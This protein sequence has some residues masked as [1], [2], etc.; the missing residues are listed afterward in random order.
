MRV[1]AGYEPDIGFLLRRD[2]ERFAPRIA[3]RPL[4]RRWGLRNWFTEA[5]V[6][7]YGRAS[8]GQ[9]ESR[10][11]EIAPIGL[12]TLREDGF[13]LY[14][15]WETERLFQPFAIRPGIVIPAGLYHFENIRLGGR[16]NESR[17]ISA[18]GRVGTGD[19]F[20]GT[21]NWAN[22]TVRLRGSRHFRAETIVD[23][24]DVDL[25][26]G[27]FITRV[28]GQRL[29]VSFTPDLRINGFLQ[30]NDAAELVGANVRFNWTYRP[31]ADLF[32]VYNENWDAPT[33]SARETVGRTL[34]L[35]YTYLWQ[36]R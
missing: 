22:V 4:I 8:T 3:W 9:L 33:F 21:R 35:K 7:Y 24:N 26:Q 23:Y 34:I 5:R 12:G 20:S 29:D 13:G 30:Y 16:T 1:N 11:V 2:F 28:I 10:R 17:R 14:Y 18:R 32:L 27:A 19:F 6:D 15:D 31:G 25:P 36:P